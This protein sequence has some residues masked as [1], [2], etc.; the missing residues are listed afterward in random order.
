VTRLPLRIRL[1][2][3]FA[4]AMALVLGGAGYLTL[5]RFQE[6][7]QEYPDAGETVAQQGALDDLRTE[8]LIALPLVLL[9]ATVGAY[10]L[11]AAALRPVERLRA[12][13]A[14]ITDTTPNHRLDIP[15]GRDEIARLALTLNDMLTRLQTALDR[16]RQLVADASH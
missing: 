3:V 16:E 2:A 5:S 9:V 15:P 11:A 13:T 6:T 8:L 12:Q 7:Q 10:L 4:L 1:A 14:A